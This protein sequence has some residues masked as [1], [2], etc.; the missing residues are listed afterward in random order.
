M[1]LIVD[2]GSEKVPHFESW[3]TGK[4]AF[5][6]VDWKKIEERQLQ[7]AKGIIISGAPI[8]L[9][10]IDPK[11]YLDAFEWVKSVDKPILGVCFGHQIIAMHHQA[12]IYM[13]SEDRDLRKIEVLSSDLLFEKLGQD[14]WMQEDHCEAV[15]LAPDF[16]HIARSS[17]C[18]IEGVRHK[19]K[20]MWGVQFHP[21]VNSPQ[22]I[23]LLNNFLSF[24][25]NS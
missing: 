10:L 22:G 13:I 11:P 25:T 23:Q 4:V 7:E 14:I 12:S 15:D 20:P 21:E 17:A 1:I 6:T 5:Q 16:D 8:L 9:S 2:C 24:C 19:T 3:A 18:D